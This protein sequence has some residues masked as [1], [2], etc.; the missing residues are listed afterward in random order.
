M[1]FQLFLLVQFAPLKKLLAVEREN[2]SIQK[3]VQ[4][5]KHTVDPSYA[6]SVTE[7]CRS[8]MKGTKL[9]REEENQ[10]ELP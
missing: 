3:Q 6:T 5:G 4:A 7:K 1:H 10:G 8:H 2:I 9:H